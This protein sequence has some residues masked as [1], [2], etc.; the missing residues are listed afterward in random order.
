MI[1]FDFEKILENG[2]RTLSDPVQRN[3]YYN[4]VLRAQNRLILLELI[5][6]GKIEVTNIDYDPGN[7]IGWKSK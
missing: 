7:E 6:N 3:D 1:E 5:Q 2:L 4:W